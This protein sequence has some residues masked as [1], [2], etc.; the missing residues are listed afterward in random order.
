MAIL[1]L[2]FGMFAYT[3]QAGSVLA[4]E[5]GADQLSQVVDAA[6]TRLAG[7]GTWWNDQKIKHGFMNALQVFTCTPDDTKW[8]WPNA[9]DATGLLKEVLDTSTLKVAGVEWNQAGVANYK[10]D[11]PTGFWPEYLTEMVGEI[12]THYNKTIAIERKYY[13]NS[14]LVVDAVADGR[15]VHMSEP[16]Y[17]VAGFHNNAPRI[18]AL[19]S[20]CVTVGTQGNFIVKVD[21]GITTLEQLYQQISTGAIKDVGFIDKGNADSVSS[22]LP[23]NTFYKSSITNGT[24]LADQVFNGQ[25]IAGYVS[26]G[27]PPEP[28]RFRMIPT[29][30]V[31]P[32]VVLFRKDEPT[33]ADKETETNAG[34]VAGLVILAI[35]VL[36]LVATLSV[37]I[38]RE[39][40]G[41]PVFAPL[42][43]NGGEDHKAN[44]QL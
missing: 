41:S 31:A 8:T 33:C 32:R 37:L 4:D 24:Q 30:I 44:D 10:V 16:Y 29:G 2:A 17:Y 35:A 38:V 9:A 11:P 28:E 14:G 40:R 36:V 1:L 23:T 26:E 18:E 3:A 7:R 6:I 5:R 43:G 22:I 34:V 19:H 20:S 12:S 27:S 25:I 13:A 39:K 15:E 21:S 42:L